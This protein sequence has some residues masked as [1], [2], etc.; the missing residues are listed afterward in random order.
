VPDGVGVLA[1][2]GGGGGLTA[3]LNARINEDISVKEGVLVIGGERLARF[4]VE[5]QFASGA[6]GVAFAGRHALLGEAR[7]LKIWLANRSNDDRD[8]LKQGVEEARAIAIA[9]PE[10]A[11]MIHDADIT[12]GY[13]WAAM[14]HV[15]GETLKDYLRVPRSRRDLWWLARLYANG[16]GATT[17][18]GA[19]HGDPHWGNVIVYDYMVEAGEPATRLKFIDFGTSKVGAGIT[20]K[21]HWRIATETFGRILK[22]FPSFKAVAGDIDALQ[23]KLRPGGQDPGEPEYEAL[24][25]IAR[26]DDILDGLKQEAGLFEKRA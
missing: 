11:A 7:V 8:K 25:R 23:Q 26:F 17:T 13:F 1:L 18:A 21:R 4:S 22:G 24:M 2:S 6:N 10:W 19:F 12:Q 20:R 5:R 16:I 9:N 15:P 3:L 14:E